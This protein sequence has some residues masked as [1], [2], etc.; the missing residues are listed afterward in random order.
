MAK[1]LFINPV[2]RAE[3]VPRHVP[4]GIAMLAAISMHDGHQVQI[5]DEN[6]W[7]RGARVIAE[8]LRADAWEVIAIGGITTTYGS[9]KTIVG[10]AREL[11]PRALI[12]LGGGVLTSL[13]HDIMR[14][15]PAVDV[16]VIGEAYVTFP[17]ILAMTD[18]GSCD[19][20]KIDGTIS[21]N[22]QG[23]LVLSRQRELMRELDTLPYPAWELFPLEEVYFK[24]S[25]MLFSVEGMLSRRRLD[26][27]ASYGCSLICRF[28]YHL[29]ISGDMRYETGADG[30]TR[31]AFDE[32]GSYSRDIRYHSPEHIVEMARYARQRFDVDYIAFLDENLMTMDAASKRTWLTEICRLW[33]AAGLQ[34]ACVRDGV[35]HDAHCRGVHWDGTSHA[36]LCNPE[37]LKIMR[38]AGCASLV[39]GYESFSA[40]ILKKM[41]KGTTPKHNIRSFFW[42]LEAGIRPV[43]NQIIG[44]PSE[45]F[46]SIYD[47]MRAWEQLGIVVRPFYAT[48]Y[49]GSEWF[50]TYRKR[51]L[52][53]YGGDLERYLLDL[54]DATKITGVISHNFNP[55][56]LL[57]LRELMINMDYNRIREYE[58]LWRQHHNI[59]APA[60]ATL[61]REPPQQMPPLAVQLVD[62]RGRR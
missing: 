32:P 34:P 39:Y 28:C 18:A 44:F 17:E 5:Y 20:P 10:L 11:C 61:Y 3:D 36:T 29:G 26:I 30:V 1:V 24:N 25:E 23:Q 9:I 14:L 48:P 4:Y 58:N 46:S 2:V 49:P 7:R 40:Q 31:V 21:R 16:G 53:Q 62:T 35:P 60:P 6:A 22:A 19:W 8:V 56:E 15:L 38:H 41:G 12:V 55:V 50:T 43:P 47:N 37:I 57:G 54:G 33:I 42:T 52:D 59:P 13:P 27:N 51:I 45:D